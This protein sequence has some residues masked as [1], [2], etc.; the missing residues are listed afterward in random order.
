[1]NNINLNE[2]E[3]NAIV[4][5]MEGDWL[6]EN[7]KDG[8]K[9][10]FKLYIRKDNCRL[11]K[12]VKNIIVENIEFSGVVDWSGHWLCF[13]QDNYFISFA[14][15][16]ILIFGKYESEGAITTIGNSLW[17]YKFKRKKN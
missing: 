9:E 13:K 16:D 15:E 1:M 10:K 14:N 4:Q 17:Q 11:I 8:E 12:L 6:T 3:R 2:Q 5:N 7:L